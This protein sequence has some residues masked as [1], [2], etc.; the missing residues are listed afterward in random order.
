MSF[1]EPLESG[2]CQ[3]EE[4]ICP[5][6]ILEVE[7]ADAPRELMIERR[8]DVGARHRIENRET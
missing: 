2:I 8:F 4:P 7:V 1:G 3:L 6:R 5:N